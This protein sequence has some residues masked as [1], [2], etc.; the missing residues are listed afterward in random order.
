MICDFTQHQWD[1]QLQAE[2]L[3]IFRQSLHEDL[4][5]RGDITSTALVPADAVGRATIV[6]RKSGV[7]CG[8]LGACAAAAAME[9]PIEFRHLCSD[10][11][12][13]GSGTAV[14]EI[15]GSARGI[16][17]AERSLL[18][19]LG[20]LS[21]VAG[22]TAK[23]V[24]AVA[25]TKA[26]IYDTRKTTPGWRRLEKYAVRCGGGRNHRSGLFD[27]ILIKDNHLAF[28]RRW[29]AVGESCR[30]SSAD[31]ASRPGSSGAELL[32]ATSP[33]AAVVAARCWAEQ[34]G[35]ERVIIEVEV[36]TLEQ[37]E[38]VLPAQPDI[39]LLDNMSADMMAR[40]VQ[41]RDRLGPGIELEASGGMTIERAIAAARVG[42]DRISVGALTHS[43]T[44]LDLGLDWAE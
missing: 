9:P 44:S 17:A 25:D 40:A 35:L 6:S 8:L 41:L 24:A 28:R 37:L 14:A 43:A 20:K 7:I 18:N 27:A 29:L 4:G 13:V 32:D 22:L 33:A 2:W 36:D 34:N 3:S 1:D 16:L 19:I 15:A 26:R 12:P 38:G 5:L 42:V 39:V 11:T 10:G 30:A 21:G 23:Y 31:S